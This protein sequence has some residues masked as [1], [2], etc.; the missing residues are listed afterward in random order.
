MFL[1]YYSVKV[2]VGHPVYS[3]ILTLY[4]MELLQQTD[5]WQYNLCKH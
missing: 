2:K 1:S 5:Y 3:P 4:R